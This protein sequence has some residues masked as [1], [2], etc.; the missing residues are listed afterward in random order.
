M[1]IDSLLASNKTNMAAD[2]KSVLNHSIY[3]QNLGVLEEA[4]QL[5]YS[6]NYDYEKYDKFIDS[7]VSE[8]LLSKFEKELSL[9]S[10]GS[11]ADRCRRIRSKLNESWTIRKF[12]RFVFRNSV[13]D[14]TNLFEL[15]E[16]HKKMGVIGYI[17]ADEGLSIVN[18]PQHA[19]KYCVKPSPQYIMTLLATF[20]EVSSLLQ[21]YT[22][23]LTLMRGQLKRR[24]DKLSE[25]DYQINKEE[26]SYKFQSEAIENRKT[27]L[28]QLQEEDVRNQQEIERLTRKIQD[29]QN[30]LATLQYLSGNM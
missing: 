6:L 24:K 20:S 26:Q 28:I 17:Y 15:F 27:K 30:E 8:D 16:G 13:E 1:V 9:P 10:N 18:V 25:E 11:R 21:G 14:T 22:E 4:D 3:W 5:A 7:F 23:H 29:Q 12:L 2:G 19:Q